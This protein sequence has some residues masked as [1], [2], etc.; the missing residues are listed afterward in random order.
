MSKAGNTKYGTKQGF[1]L[2]ELMVVV[3][4]I[5]LIAS[6]AIPAFT[7]SRQSSIATRTS[8]DFRQFADKFNLYNLATGDWPADGYPATVPDGM[9]ESLAGGGW[10]H[11]SP[12]G[13][14]WDY[15]YDQFGFTAG[16][17]IQSLTANDETLTA[18]DRLI[19]D[20]NLETGALYKT[21]P[22]RLSFVL[23]E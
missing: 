8:N 5:G 19:D 21:G 7:Q 11:T 15:D 12:I 17:S 18:I 10:Q 1:T 3:T 14:N 16:V 13:G 2:V 6:I 20:G 4:I 23:A 22:D 9:S